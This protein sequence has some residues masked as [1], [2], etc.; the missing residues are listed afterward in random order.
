M[1]AS[2]KHEAA[3]QFALSGAGGPGDQSVGPVRHQ[4]DCDGA[5]LGHSERGGELRLAA[6]RRPPGGDDLRRRIASPDQFEETHPLGKP[7]RFVIG[8]GIGQT[9][10]G[11]SHALGYIGRG[12]RGKR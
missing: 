1:R 7:C 6:C 4:I 9:G 8:F 12:T 11:P 5:M 10:E 3:E 2:E